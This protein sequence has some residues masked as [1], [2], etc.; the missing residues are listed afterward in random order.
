M[1]LGKTVFILLIYIIKRWIAIADAD[2]EKDRK[3]KTG[4][5][6]PVL[7][8]TYQQLINAAQFYN[9][10]LFLYPCIKESTTAF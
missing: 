7:I 2:I 9:K 1:G 4:A 8:N 10:F 5:Y 6:L 3:R